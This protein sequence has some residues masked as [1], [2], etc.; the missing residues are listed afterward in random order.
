MGLRGE[1]VYRILVGKPEAK[2][3]LG[4]LGVNVWIV[5]GWICGKRACIVSCWGYRIERY[6]WGDLGVHVW[7]LLGWI[8]GM[9]AVY[10]VLVGKL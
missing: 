10:M 1:G 5:L 8:C 6:H 9:C 3:T 2:R 7:I 4:G